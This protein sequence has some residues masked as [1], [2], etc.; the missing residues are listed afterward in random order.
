MKKLKNWA[1]EVS[2]PLD[3]AMRSLEIHVTCIMSRKTDGNLL[4]RHFRLKPSSSSGC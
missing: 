2:T 1:G 3:I 4:V